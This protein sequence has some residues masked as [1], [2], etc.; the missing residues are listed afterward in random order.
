MFVS[1]RSAPAASRGGRSPAVAGSEPAFRLRNQARR[2]FGDSPRRERD[3]TRRMHDTFPPTEQRAALL[4]IAEA[5]GSRSS[6]LRRDE[7]SDWR[8]NGRR[9]HIYAAHEGT[10]IYFMGSARG[11]T[12]AKAALSF[13]KV[14]QDG[15]QEGFLF[16][17][18]PPTNAEGDIIRDKLGIPKKRELSA[19]ELA[20]LR[21]LA[22]T[23]SPFRP[24][25]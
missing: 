14:L 18:R 24:K 20:R 12:L 25:D 22:P 21:A 9:G 5:I 4:V 13:A 15:D 17:D 1:G 11:W 23:I 2:Y 6:A 10:Y 16:L 19:E 8:I 3:G 7:C